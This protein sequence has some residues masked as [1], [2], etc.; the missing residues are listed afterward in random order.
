MTGRNYDVIVQ[1]ANNIAESYSNYPAIKGKFESGNVVVGTSS[2]ATGTIANINLSDNTIKV[3]YTNTYERF[4][5]SD[6]LQ[7]KAIIPLVHNTSFT[8]DNS[9]ATAATTV[10]SADLAAFNAQLTDVRIATRLGPG[11]NT[12]LLPISAN[13][14]SEITVIVDNVQLNP[15][16]YIWTNDLQPNVDGRISEFVTIGGSTTFTNISSLGAN[17]VFIRNTIGFD[18]NSFATVRVDSGNLQSRAFS[19]TNA[20]IAASTVTANSTSILSITNSPFIAEKNAFT[21]NPIVRLISIYYPGEYYPPNKYGNPSL[22][23]EGRGWPNDFP[24][25]IAEVNGDII[26]DISYN[27]TYNGESYSPYPLNVGSINQAADGKIND[28]EI[29]IFNF[30][31]T[32]SALVED[33]FISGN[34]TT[35]ACMAMVN[36]QLVNGIDPRTINFTPAQVGGSAGN[37][38]FDTLT[39]ARANGL[40]YDASV[41]STYGKA[42]ASFT[43]EQSDI[44]GGTWQ[45]EKTDSRDLLGAIVEIKTTFANFLDHWPEYST[46]KSQYNNVYEMISTMPYRVG[47]NVKSSKGSTEA[48]VTAIEENRFLFLSNELAADT[49]PTDPVYIVNVDADPESFIEDVFKI[50]SLEGLNETAATFTLVSWLQYFKYVLPKRKFYKNTCSWEYKGAECQYPGP[51]DGTQGLAIPGTTKFGNPKSVKADGTETTVPLDDVCGKSLA[52]CQQRNN[53]IHFGGFPATGRTIP[54][55]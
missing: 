9:N 53:D 43:K 46:V 5:T 30:E 34:N 20:N 6:N 47:D 44:V 12:L 11:T 25:R 33:P 48:T 32:I 3:K 42:N 15:E 51:G 8:Y 39:R 45:E 7:S 37:T 50:D 13:S 35:H 52:S 2:G 38:A 27:V 4:S 28:L 21:Q 24:F 14:N 41:V 23:G 18:A 54:R 26:S 55:M 16:D 10:N 22:N 19:A 29:S 31:N 1:F 40:A 36:D 49:A 17:A